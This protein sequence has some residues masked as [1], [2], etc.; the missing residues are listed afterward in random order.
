MSLGQQSKQTIGGNS[1]FDI[2]QIAKGSVT[3]EFT[4]IASA[5]LQIIRDKIA[6]FE[7]KNE[8]LDTMLNEEGDKLDFEI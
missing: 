1:I 2:R 3:E 4:S 8:E 6:E 7:K 5:E